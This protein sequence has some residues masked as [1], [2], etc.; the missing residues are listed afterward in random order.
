MSANS[1][2][3]TYCGKYNKPHLV[4]GTSSECFQKGFRVGFRKGREDALS[5]IQANSQPRQQEHNFYKNAIANIEQ[6]ISDML[7]QQSKKK[8]KKKSKSKSPRRKRK[9]NVLD[10]L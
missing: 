4:K 9:I 8:K 1:S 10:L 2:P 3:K 6:L 5:E 7:E